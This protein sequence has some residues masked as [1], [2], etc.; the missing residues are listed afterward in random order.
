MDKILNDY[1]EKVDKYLKPMKVTDRMDIIKEIESDMAEL[2]EHGGLSANEIIDRLGEP[3]KLAQAYL[4]ETI[5]ETK[6]MSFRK[7]GAMIAFYS[8]AGLGGII[9]LPVTGITSIAL[10]LSGILCPLCGLVKL[11]A[12]FV[13]YDIPFI[14]FQLGSFSAS[15]ALTLILSIIVGTCF[16]GQSDGARWDLRSSLRLLSVLLLRLPGIYA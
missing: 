7:L 13:G 8:M 3:K 6:G 12:S 14:G 2:R 1:L 5:T 9:I 11:L 10:I 4:G 15:P 16:C